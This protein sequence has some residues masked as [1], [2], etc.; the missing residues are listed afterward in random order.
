MY[1]CTFMHLYAYNIYVV[2][3]MKTTEGVVQGLKL[4][5]AYDFLETMKNIVEE[6][7]GRRAKAILEA[8]PQLIPAFLDIQRRLGM[9]NIGVAAD[10]KP[11]S[12]SV[13]ESI[14]TAPTISQSSYQQHLLQQVCSTNKCI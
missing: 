5:Q 1:I 8:Y 7:H 3:A 12:L 9:V 11:T 14:N 6:D 4:H 2:T 13:I 10:Q